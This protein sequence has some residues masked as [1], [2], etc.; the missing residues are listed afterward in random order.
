[1]AFFIYILS[2]INI[3]I[4]RNIRNKRIEV[5]KDMK[6]K[7]EDKRVATEEEKGDRRDERREIEL[8]GILDEICD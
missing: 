8:P 6:D 4:I 7:V 2:S 3:A 5:R 1:M